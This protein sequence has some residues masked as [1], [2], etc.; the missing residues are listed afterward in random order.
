MENPFH[1]TGVRTAPSITR[2]AEH[3]WYP[4]GLEAGL[5]GLAL[6]QSLVDRALV[7]TLCLG[8]FRRAPADEK[9]NI[10]TQRIVSGR[11]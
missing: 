3:V 6:L 5:L 1:E 7:F 2:A 10:Q 4:L 11:L 9:L 8:L